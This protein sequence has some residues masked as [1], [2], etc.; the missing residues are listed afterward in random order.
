MNEPRAALIRTITENLSTFAAPESIEALFVVTC[1]DLIAAG[2]D[3]VRVQASMMRAFVRQQI[4]Q[5]GAGATAEL[6][7]DF[8]DR[9]ERPSL[10]SQMQ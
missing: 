7:R 2:I 10:N 8:A 4:A 6:L 9:I 5:R 3:P 1:E